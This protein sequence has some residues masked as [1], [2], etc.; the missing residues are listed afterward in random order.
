[1]SDADLK[2]RIDRMKIENEF[3]K[4][5]KEDIS[6]GKKIASD[7]LSSAGKKT[8]TVAAAGAMAYGVKVAMTR[9]FDIKE[10]TDFIVANPTNKK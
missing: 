8:L 7:I 6:P 5:T 3:K 2:K 9:K 1:M 10:A 4:L